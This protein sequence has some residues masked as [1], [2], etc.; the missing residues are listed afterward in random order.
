VKGG[1]RS[2]DTNLGRQVAAHSDYIQ[3]IIPLAIL[4]P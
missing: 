1:K 3:G 4:D 2:E